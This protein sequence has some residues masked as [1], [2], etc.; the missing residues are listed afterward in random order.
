[1]VIVGVSG[2]DGAG[3]STAVSGL[4]TR[5]AAEGVSVR[6]VYLYGCLACRRAPGSSGGGGS[7]ARSG[8]VHR[9]HAIVDA[10]ELAT[11]LALAT[12]GRPAVLVT[13]RTPLDGLVKHG[14]LAGPR[15]LAGRLY[16]AAARRY[17]LIALLDAPASVLAERDRDHD[18]ATLERLRRRFA[19]AA[20]ALPNVQEISSCNSG[21]EPDLFGFVS[22]R[23]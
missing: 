4:G 13:D 18:E 5:L 17:S 20:A 10:A 23:I 22:K 16:R 12:R 6:Q 2:P 3:K 11:R 14:D 15:T 21:G 9:L 19:N 8:L 7:G 1:M